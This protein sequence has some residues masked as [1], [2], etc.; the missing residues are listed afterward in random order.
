MNRPVFALFMTAFIAGGVITVSGQAPEKP[1]QGFLAALKSGQSVSM[2]EVA[3]RFEFMIDDSVTE[4]R[5]KITEVGADFVTLEDIAGVSETRIPLYA[6][7]S[8]VTIKVP[9]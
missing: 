2:K 8:I 3:G 1:R 7:K 9:K 6:I 4:L 5:H